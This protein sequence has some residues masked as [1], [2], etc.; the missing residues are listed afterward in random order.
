[1]EVCWGLIFGNVMCQSLE[2][3]TSSSFMHF[4]AE[5]FFFPSHPSPFSGDWET[6]HP[7]WLTTL[8]GM[9]IPS[10]VFSFFLKALSQF[11]VSTPASSWIL[12]LVVFSLLSLSPTSGAEIFLQLFGCREGPRTYY[13]AAGGF[14][15]LATAPDR[16]V[17]SLNLC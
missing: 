16:S 5:M 4:S 13:E 8:Y 7:A 3:G 10:E 11:Y 15:L 12:H 2:F 9:F 17:A 14:L 1:M 6:S